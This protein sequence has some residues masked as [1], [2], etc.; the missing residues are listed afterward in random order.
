MENAPGHEDQPTRRPPAARRR[1]SVHEAAPILGVSTFM[2]RALIRQRRLP[3]YKVGRRVVLDVA[4]LEA[5]LLEHRVEA[6][7]R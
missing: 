3:Y 2:V 7:A 5:Y 6:R 4:D 1:L